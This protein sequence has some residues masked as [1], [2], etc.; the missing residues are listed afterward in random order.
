MNN[1]SSISGA[2]SNGVDSGAGAAAIAAVDGAM[3]AVPREI[4]N[5]LADIED[6]ITSATSLTGEDLTR[7]K[8]KLGARVASAKA[9]AEEMGGVVVDRARKTIK[10]GNDYVHEQ[11]WQ[12]IGIGAALG[13][14]L[15]LVLAR[16]A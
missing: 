14:L 16:R 9:A 8:A 4:H 15:G 10:V 6:L 12:A 13:L 11:P 2:G 3:S 1:Q 7:A 5:F